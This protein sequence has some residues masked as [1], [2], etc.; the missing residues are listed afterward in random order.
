MYKSAHLIGYRAGC[1]WAPE[2]TNRAPIIDYNTFNCG[3]DLYTT[4]NDRYEEGAL[5]T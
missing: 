1:L 3:G 4:K 2:G 5:P